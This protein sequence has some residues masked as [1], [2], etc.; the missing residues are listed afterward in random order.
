MKRYIIAFDEGTTSAR[1]LIY[2]TLLDTNVITVNKPIRQIY[3][4]PGY[5]EQSP[6]EIWAAQ[7]AA[8][9][10]AVAL[11]GI[12]GEEIAGAGITNQRETVVVWDKSTGEPI[13]DAIVW[14]CRRTAKEC[15]RLIEEGLSE[16]I[17]E[18]T[19]LVIDAYFSATKINWILNHVEGAREKAKNGRLLCGTVDTWL[20][21]KM[22]N[23]K[24]FVTDYTNASRT[25]LFN[26][27]TLQWDEDL[28][29]VFD[30]PR[31]MLPDV[32]NCN[33]ETGR[34]NVFGVD[35]PIA[36]I[37]GDQQSSLFGQGCFEKGMAKNTYGTGCFIL[38]NMGRE[39]GCSPE[40][41]LTSIAWGLEGE[42]T[43]AM[44][45]SVFNAGSSLKWLQ[46][47]LGLVASAAEADR[48]CESVE[49]TNGVYM[50]PAF[51]GL[52]A[53]YWDMNARGAIFGLT[54]GANKYHIVRA[55]M[56]SIAYRTKDIID[57]ME[58]QCGIKLK[59]L[60]VDGGAS[61]SDFLM[62]FQSDLLRKNV[63]I[64]KS[65]DSTAMGVVYLAA[66][67]MGLLDLQE[68]KKR[69]QVKKEFIPVMAEHLAQAKYAGW[70][71]AVE[72][73]IR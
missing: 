12:R 1:A 49:N 22:T 48:F 50:V 8:F 60:R 73:T 14:Q 15:E 54:R 46:E 39:I 18:K 16:M 31:S 11:S 20:I 69:I 3:P 27:H 5:V 72:K 56:E 42:I 26:I 28:L 4:K 37:A 24:K 61:K 6:K 7:L 25:M 36:A 41:M 17:R 33:E 51:T 13:C 67:G 43:Y 21:W 71:N 34:L 53:P 52:G 66:M 45:G 58:E 40:K 44:E 32:V 23:G 47:E 35:V 63:L 57:T 65:S 9:A 2:D 19:G 68:I 64:A 38:M 30:I 62:Q 10:E 59:E 70:K 55:T 29:K